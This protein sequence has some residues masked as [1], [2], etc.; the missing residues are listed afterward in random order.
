MYNWVSSAYNVVIEAMLPD[1]V[2]KSMGIKGVEFRS[3]NRSLRYTKL[4]LAW[5]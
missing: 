2:A 5:F 1:E 3:Q 4:K